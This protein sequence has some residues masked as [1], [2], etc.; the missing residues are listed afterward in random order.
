[1]AEYLRLVEEGASKEDLALAFLLIL[2]EV[3]K[4]HKD[5]AKLLGITPRAMTERVSGRA[6]IKRETCLAMLW[7]L[8]HEYLREKV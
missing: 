2:R 7:I 3:K 5:I 1:M 8:K 4:K 6:E